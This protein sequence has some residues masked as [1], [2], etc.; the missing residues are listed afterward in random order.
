MC[1]KRQFLQKT[2]PIQ[3]P[4]LCFIVCRISLSSLTLHNTSTF[5]TRSVQLIFS[6]ATFQNFQ[7]NYDLLSEV[8]KFQPHT[9]L[10]SLFP[11]NSSPMLVKRIFLLKADFAM[12]ILG[13]IAREHLES[14]VIMLATLLKYST[15]SSFFCITIC[16][17]DGCLRSSSL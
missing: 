15:F 14:F 9:K 11:L 4:L 16:T 10:C 7:H 6:N 2:W 5:L 12:T 1:S 13:L 8:S 17:M 3:L